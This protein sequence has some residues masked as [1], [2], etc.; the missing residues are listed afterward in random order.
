MPYY[1]DLSPYV[2]R[3]NCPGLI[4]IG[5]LDLNRAFTKGFVEPTI[6]AEIGRLCSR[7]VNLTRGYQVCCGQMPVME[8]YLGDG[9]PRSLGNGE[10]HV[11]GGSI[12][13][14]YAAPTLIYHYITRHEYLPPQ[15]FLD[16]VKSTIK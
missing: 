10:I 4:N 5:W 8:A 7:P 12:Y 9:V 3:L 14:E 13:W 16:A 6:T 2:F 1:P 11:S 15:E